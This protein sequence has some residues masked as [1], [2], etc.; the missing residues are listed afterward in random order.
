MTDSWDKRQAE[1][2]KAVE[3]FRDRASEYGFVDVKP[4]GVE[5]DN[6][7]VY[8]QLRKRMDKTSVML[9]HRPD[10]TCFMVDATVLMQ[11]KGEPPS[12]YN[13]KRDKVFIEVDSWAGAM[14][15]NTVYRHVAFAFVA[16][17]TQIIL[18]AWAD[19]LSFKTIHV[20]MKHIH[21]E[22][23]YERMQMEYPDKNVISEEWGGGSGTPCFTYKKEELS[24][25]LDFNDRVLETVNVTPSAEQNGD[26]VTINTKYHREPNGQL[27]IWGVV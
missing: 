23:N 24:D 25:Y 14:E 21:Y 12:K 22:D 18:F 27:S 2:K 20:P 6:K 9:R 11:I 13:G 1:A 7:D 10:A 4:M 16:I 15:W 17:E 26:I 5:F 3:I 8:C 19:E